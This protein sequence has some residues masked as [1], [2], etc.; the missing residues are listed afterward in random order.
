MGWSGA[1]AND[2]ALAAWKHDDVRKAFAAFDK[3]RTPF[4]RSK[5]HNAL[6]QKAGIADNRKRARVIEH[7]IGTVKFRELLAQQSPA[8]DPGRSS[9]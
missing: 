9:R 1:A 5:F 7:M 2:L 3:D 4:N 6:A 8:Q